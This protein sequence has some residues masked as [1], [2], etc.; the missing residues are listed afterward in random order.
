MNHERMM[1]TK[2]STLYLC[3]SHFF[4]S[5]FHLG[6]KKIDSYKIDSSTKKKWKKKKGLMV[7]VKERSLGCG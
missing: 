2:H 3:I 6:F 1:N 7:I 4:F 5:S